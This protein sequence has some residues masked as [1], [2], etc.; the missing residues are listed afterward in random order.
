MY[1]AVGRQTIRAAVE[2]GPGSMVQSPSILSPVPTE[3]GMVEC[4]MLYNAISRRGYLLADAVLGFLW[5]P[6]R[7]RQVNNRGDIIEAEEL[8]EERIQSQ[9]M[10][11]FPGHR[12]TTSTL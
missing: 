7:Q 9:P 12:T 2:R 5:G 6:R 8:P 4:C 11:V 3:A 10:R 1:R